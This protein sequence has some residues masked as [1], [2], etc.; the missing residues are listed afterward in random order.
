MAT[1]LNRRRKHRRRPGE[2]GLTLAES[3]ATCV[4]LAVLA[5]CVLP[6]L[7]GLA[8]DGKFARCLSHLQRIGM[9]GG[10]Y[11][12]AD[13]AD[14]AIPVHAAFF[15]QDP[16]DVIWVGP[17]EWGG[18][19]GRGETD[20]VTG[21]P[22]DPVDS[23]YGTQAG[24]GPARRPLNRI[25]YGDT[26]TDYTND[27]GPGNQNWLQDTQLDLD[28]FRCPCDSGY[29]GIH[30]PAF[31]DDRLT[32]Y[33]HFGT[34]YGA[35]MFMIA[36]SG[37]GNPMRSNSPFLHAQ[38]AIYSPAT[39]LAYQENNGRFAWA[40]YPDS[41]DFIDGI[42]GHV[43]GWHGKDW[44]FNAS[45]IDGHA[46]AIYMNGYR[47]TYLPRFEGADAGGVPDDNGYYRCVMIRGEGWQK[48]T[49]PLREIQTGLYSPSSD[50][51]SY[52]GGIE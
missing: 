32:S 30:T 17:Y 3:L 23:R 51:P 16:A 2:R 10:I 37:G 24:F 31:R 7:A 42:P 21:T 47:S 44:T 5:A 25:L 11:A 29:T 26:L 20:F 18:K 6:A 50:R 46:E 36:T 49:L 28:L 33:D 19:S 43:R 12:A 14:S 8:Q 48:D 9:A 15:E 27:P 38:S 22:G 40:S 35:N 4:A 39:T 45:F 41:C 52:E 13:A 34:S 1:N